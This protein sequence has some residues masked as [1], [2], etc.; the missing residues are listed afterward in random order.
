MALACRCPGRG[1]R[2]QPFRMSNAMRLRLPIRWNAIASTRTGRGPR[3]DHAAAALRPGRRTSARPHRSDRRADR[4]A[5]AGSA[6]GS[7]IRRSASSSGRPDLECFRAPP[8]TA[9]SDAGSSPGRRRS[10]ATPPL[11]RFDPSR[12]L[13]A[14][15]SACRADRRYSGDPSMDAPCASRRDPGVPTA[16]TSSR[17]SARTSCAPSSGFAS[18]PRCEAPGVTA[19]AEAPIADQ[20]C[21]RRNPDRRSGLRL[22]SAAV[23][24]DPT[25]SEVGAA[26][27]R[28]LGAEQ[29]VGPGHPARRV[30]LDQAGPPQRRPRH[31]A[32]Q[33]RPE[34]GH[35]PGPGRARRSSGRTRR[36]RGPR[37]G[38]NRPP[39]SGR[40]SSTT[41]ITSPPVGGV[42]CGPPGTG[43]RRAGAATGGRSRGSPR[44]PAGRRAASGSGWSTG[45]ACHRP[46]VTRSTSSR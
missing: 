3:V 1:S 30:L 32:E 25:G 5:A 6:C 35:A 7:A 44:R 42:A 26:V 14:R 19:I 13:A 4:V 20:A 15:A 12:H 40:S 8:A 18:W 21:R 34:V 39:T 28:A 22:T 38:R 16:R 33:Q 27:G 36:R 37:R 2:Q 46:G 45:A 43:P 29:R 9:W 31:A 10:G 23:C 11:P 17:P 41:S 24:R